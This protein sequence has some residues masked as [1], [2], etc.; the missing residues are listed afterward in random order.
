[1][2]TLPERAITKDTFL[3]QKDLSVWQDKQL[4]NKH[5]LFS[6]SC[7]LYSSPLMIQTP[8]SFSLVQDSV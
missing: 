2:G 1:M 8:T 5:L 6:F 7:E 3:Q 4:F